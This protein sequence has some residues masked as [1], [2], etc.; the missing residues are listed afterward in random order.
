MVNIR[1]PKISTGGEVRLKDRE[2][3]SEARAWDE[4]LTLE[5]TGAKL[6]VAGLEIVKVHDIPVIYLAGDSTVTDQ[7]REPHNNW[8][9][10]FPRF[11]Q[12][13]SGD[14]QSRRI[15]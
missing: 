15:G 5:L 14:R 10:M 2:K 13:Q 12:R 6:A 7:P 3:T 8:G 1:T 11:F 4:K 9:Q